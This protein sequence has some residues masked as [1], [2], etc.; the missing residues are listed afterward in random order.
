MRRHAPE[1]GFSLV[2]L[3]VV[4]AIIGVLVS[5]LIPAVNWAI[6]YSKEGASLTLVKNLELALIEYDGD[7]GVYPKPW[8][9]NRRWR[10]DAAPYNQLDKFSKKGKQY[11]SFDASKFGA[12]DDGAGSTFLKSPL[13]YDMWYH[14]WSSV[15]PS[16]KETDA[17]AHNKNTADIW[18][19]GCDKVKEPKKINNWGG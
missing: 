12:G 5:M 7:Y 2:E 18:T 3:L 9:Q 16:V 15:K 17:N 4:I 11:L 13:G 1:Q 8:N 14:E 19:P 6:C 10:S